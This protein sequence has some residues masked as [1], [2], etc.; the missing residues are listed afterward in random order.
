LHVGI[1]VAIHRS[2]RGSE[3]DRADDDKNHG[4]G[5]AE[6]K[7]AAT[8]LLEEEE[9][10]DS[11]DDRGTEKGADRA[12]RATASWVVAHRYSSLRVLR[13]LELT[14]AAEAAICLTYFLSRLRPRPTDQI[15]ISQIHTQRTLILLRYVAL[16]LTIPEAVAKHKNSERDENQRPELLDAP[17]WKP[18]EIVQQ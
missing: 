10:A 17:P 4:I 15:R 11:D 14:S 8:H 3:K 2:E 6:I 12:S 18:I 16:L 5:V 9:D 13:F 1:D 7:V